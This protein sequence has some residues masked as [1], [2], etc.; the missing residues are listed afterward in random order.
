M[1]KVIILV[2]L[3]ALTVPVTAIADSPDLSVPFNK[4]SGIEEALKTLSTNIDKIAGA[5][6]QPDRVYALQDMAGLC[7]TSKMQVH[8]LNSLFSVVN[9]V[10]REKKFQSREAKL[11]K[12]K[13]GYALN[14]FKRRKTFVTDILNKASEQKLKDLA[15]IFSAQLSIVLKQ[16]DLINQKLH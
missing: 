13:C 10:K 2:L 5:D 12:I 3:F 6:T 7:K 14:D 4:L 15:Q 8:S 11:L 9:L 16:L 1:H